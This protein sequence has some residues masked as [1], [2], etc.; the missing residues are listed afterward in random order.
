MKAPARTPDEAGGR[1]GVEIPES[2]VRR[3][4]RRAATVWP[5][6]ACGVLI[7]HRDGAS[8]AVHRAGLCRNIDPCPGA[9]YELHPR[10][11]LRWDRAAGRREWEVVGIW[12]SHPGGAPVPSATD[13]ERAWRG[14]SYL[15]VAVEPACAP[16]LR[17]WRMRGEGFVEEPISRR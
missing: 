1:V 8:V 10:D 17:C 12:H 2:E 14:W 13:R 3:I 7:G 11:F 5:R 9:R 15:I 4:A 16:A 6:E